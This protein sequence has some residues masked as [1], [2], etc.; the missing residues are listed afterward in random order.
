MVSVRAA[1]LWKKLLLSDT[2]A[3]VRF[4]CADGCAGGEGAASAALPAHRCVLATA[5]EYFAALFDRWDHS[6][7]GTGAPRTRR[8]S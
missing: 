4:V 5:S 3:D 7:D 6:A 8:R 1:A 2:H